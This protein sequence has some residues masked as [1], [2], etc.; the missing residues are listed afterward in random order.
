VNWF[1]LSQRPC[2]TCQEGS[3]GAIVA[4]AVAA[5]TG[6]FVTMGGSAETSTVATPNQPQRDTVVAMNDQS[7]ER[8]QGD[9]TD[10][11]LDKVVKTDEQWREILTPEQYR[12]MRQGGTEAPF[13]GEY[14]S[15]TTPG[16]YVCAGCG[17]PLFESDAKFASGCGW[18]SFNEPAQDKAIDQREDRSHGLVRTEVRCKRCDAHLGHVFNDGPPP[19]GL[20]YCINSAAI[21]LI[22]R[23]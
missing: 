5:A 16:R 21:R 19:T 14:W 3:V 23:Q 2:T 13:T 20:R 7:R 15:T 8:T 4:V 18:P 6:V 11:Q 12:V 10:E 9:R 17:E 22:E 1:G